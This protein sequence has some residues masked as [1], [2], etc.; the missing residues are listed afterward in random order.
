MAIG[1][2]FILFLKLF[3][4]GSDAGQAATNDGDNYSRAADG[5]SG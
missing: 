4:S 2:F 5:I 3:F 1:N